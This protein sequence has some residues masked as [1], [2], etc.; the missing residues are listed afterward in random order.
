ME[1]LTPEEIK[2][3]TD[4]LSAWTVLEILSPKR[5][6][7]A[8]DLTPGKVDHIHFLKQNE[9]LPWQEK[10]RYKYKKPF[11]QIVIG[12]IDY[13][14]AIDLL[15]SKYKEISS[16]EEYEKPQIE[17][18]TIMGVLTVDDQGKLIQDENQDIILSTF[19]WGTP[20]ILN[21]NLKK[22]RNWP[23][24]EEK[25]KEIREDILNNLQVKDKDDKLIPLTLESIN[26]AYI[27]LVKA[28]GLDK[29]GTEIT[30]DNKFAVECYPDSKDIKYPKPLMLSS[31]FVGDLLK[32][33]QLLNGGTA[34]ETLIK[35]LNLR[36]PKNEN[37]VL[38][39]I[40][41]LEEVV[42]PGNIPLA[43]WP[44]PKGNNLVLLQQAAVNIAMNKLSDNDILG[45]NGPPGTGKTTLL[46]DLVAAIVSNRAEKM[47]AFDNPET[48]FTKLSKPIKLNE[49]ELNLYSL[50]ESL[51]GFEILIASSNNKAVENISAALPGKKT[52]TQ[53]IEL[54]YF[55]TISD[56][57]LQQGDETWGLI[58]AVFGN[59]TNIKAFYQQFRNNADAS[60]DNYLLAV[61]EGIKK[62]VQDIDPSTGKPTG[63]HRF[64][65][66]LTENGGPPS[67]FKQAIEIWE[68]TKEKFKA[69]S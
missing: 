45:I 2:K 31:F 48:A 25:I 10:P 46:R 5:F 28:F 57:L 44:S 43:K 34:P 1:K 62:K 39:D 7:E 41:I 55:K 61:I 27:D 63:Q 40:S 58:S 14:K 68:K 11:Y 56:A 6:K 29:L 36:A 19:A 8:E 9:K 3:G 47:V 65:H 49:S 52:I 50:H 69:I 53:D 21:N 66:I 22:L 60:M 13:K 54:T 4:T 64:A 38:K 24:V 42:A 16:E 51:K 59:N 33:G 37:D 20:Q 26:Q 32:A 35:Y 30:I 67:S 17:G 23:A 18:Q 15:V 12:T